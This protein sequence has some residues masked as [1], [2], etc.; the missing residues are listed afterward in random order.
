MEVKGRGELQLAVLIEN[1]RREGFEL[2]V[3]PPKILFRQEEGEVLEP[4]E[5]VT[6]D[7]PTEFSGVVMERFGMYISMHWIE[8]S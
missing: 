6:V 4:I 7:L 3:S 8:G 1:M 5:E 2:G